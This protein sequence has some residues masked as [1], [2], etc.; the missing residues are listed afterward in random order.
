MTTFGIRQALPTDKLGSRRTQPAP[1]WSYARP[2]APRKPSTQKRAML[3]RRS[4]SIHKFTHSPFSATHS[5]CDKSAKSIY[6]RNPVMKKQR[7]KMHDN[8]P[9]R[10]PRSVKAWPKTELFRVFH[11]LAE[12]RSSCGKS[13]GGIIRIDGQMQAQHANATAILSIRSLVSPYAETDVLRRTPS[14]V[15]FC[16]GY[17]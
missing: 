5:I 3:P 12:T 10:K 11:P 7:F 16:L 8:Q 13:A 15:L 17:I 6:R 4:S 1:L 14:V 9:S 2:H